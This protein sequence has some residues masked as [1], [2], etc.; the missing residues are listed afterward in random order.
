M[1]V[2]NNYRY[3]KAQAYGLLL[4]HYFEK[5]PYGYFVIK[6][7]MYLYNMSYRTWMKIISPHLYIP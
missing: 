5:I 4:W 1:H 6:Y 3:S 2:K 7:N